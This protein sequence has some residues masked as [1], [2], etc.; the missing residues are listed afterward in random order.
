MAIF[1]NVKGEPIS[2]SEF[3]DLYSKIYYFQNDYVEEHKISNM[4][5]DSKARKPEDYVSFL[6]WKVGDKSD[7]SSIITQYGSSIDVKS[8]IGLANEVDE[9]WSNLE[10][11]DLYGKILNKKIKNLGAVYSLALVYFISCGTKPI[12][13]KF[14]EIALDVISDDSHSFREPQIYIELPDKWDKDNVIKRYEKYENK[15][16]EVFGGLWR[17]ERDIDRA[18]W[19]YGH[20]FR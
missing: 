7:G 4:I 14:A 6:R 2:K 19:T 8:I 16:S 20:M 12:Y 5:I 13:D 18:L 3:I 17:T 9:T 11:I 1:Y 15:L 10:T